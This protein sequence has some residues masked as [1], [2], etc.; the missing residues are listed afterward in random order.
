M[1]VTA[2]T[3]KNSE[4]FSLQK[5]EETNKPAQEA[6]HASIIERTINT[7]TESTTYISSRLN[8]LSEDMLGKSLGELLPNLSG[9]QQLLFKA[10]A[11]ASITV[12]AFTILYH[13]I[14]AS[15]LT[16]I[17]LPT[18][19]N[20]NNIV[21]STKD[22]INNGIAL[23]S[24]IGTSITDKAQDIINESEAL[25][26]DII[27][28]QFIDILKQYNTNKTIVKSGLRTIETAINILP[29]S[30]LKT[31][32]HQALMAASVALLAPDSTSFF[33]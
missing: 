6:T 3:K 15:Y 16:T 17:L 33:I 24:N 29:N 2:L 8:N 1:T 25:D 20:K 18:G 10:L 30:N 32:L 4:H 26:I 12:A 31:K 5:E 28:Q 13:T 21:E 22:A 19:A 27:A 11:G 7:A 9:E 23:H 14:P